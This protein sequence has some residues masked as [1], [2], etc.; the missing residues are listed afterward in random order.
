VTGGVPTGFSSQTFEV[1]RSDDSGVTWAGIRN[2]V[3]APDSTYVAV[4]KDY[5]APRGVTVQ[6]RARAIGVTGS[7]QIASQWG[8]ERPWE[9]LMRQA[10]WYIDA[11]V[12]PGG[13]TVVNQGTGG[14]ALDARLGSGTGADTNDPKLL[15]YDPAEGAYVY[16]PGTTTD[17][18]SVPDE[19]ALDLTGDFDLRARVALDDWTPAATTFIAGK[20]ESYMLNVNTDGTLLL[21]CYIPGFAGAAST[22]PTGTADGAAR[23]VRVTRAS[24]SG[25]VKFYT[26]DDGV[27]WTQL[28][29]T[30]SLGAGALTPSAYG[31]FAGSRAAA[32]TPMKF[33]RAIV[34]N[35][36]DGL[37]VLD[38]DTSVITSG[39]ATSFTAQS[40]QTVTINR[41]TLGWKAAAVVAPVWLFGTDDYMEVPDNS[42]L[43]F[44]AIDSFTIA[45]V[46]RVWGTPSS[47]FVIAK[48]PGLADNTA[49]YVIYE[50]SGYAALR[51]A[52]GSAEGVTFGSRT[53]GMINTVSAVRT[54]ASDTFILSANGTPLNVGG[55]QTDPTTGSFANAG[56]LRVGRPNTTGTAYM[57]M[58]FIAAAVFR[59]ALTADE[60]TVISDGYQA[61]TNNYPQLAI[62]N[63]GAWWVKS[64]TAPSLNRAAVR[65]LAGLD[66]EVAED[67]GVF[68]PKGRSTALVVAGSIYGRDGTYRIATLGEDEWN[69]VYA[70]IRHQGVLLVQDP[71]GGQKY[72][73]VT[74]RRIKTTGAVGALRREAELVYVEVDG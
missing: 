65:V 22:V 23:W 38:V 53:A 10:V 41:A 48:K 30:V 9:A 64:I 12:A 37:T 45:A 16:F 28:G 35:G 21:W 50:D 31:F 47:R 46:Y 59:R 1:Q 71:A 67:T 61:W 34:K 52:D 68:R 62:P 63:D 8:G 11:N 3:L 43:D 27:A 42:L 4:V 29:A 60:V 58:E 6:Y 15:T 72:I 56:P 54:V 74:G 26:S 39:A 5:E 2:G 20:I 19:A 32:T 73:R 70:L 36:I 7:E 55:S 66:E 13:Q 24:S 51:Y 14:S 18:M 44:G 69:A 17:Y 25:D 49:G 33:Y 40:G 57:D